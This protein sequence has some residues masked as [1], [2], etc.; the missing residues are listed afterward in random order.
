VLPLFSAILA[1]AAAAS[2]TPVSLSADFD[3]DGRVETA[4]ARPIGK[5]IRVE[6]ADARGK[7][8]AWADAAAPAGALD[9]AS[10]TLTG[11]PLG[12]P[13]VLLAVSSAAAGEQCHSVFR[14]KDRALTRVPLQQGG[15]QL[16]DCA[17][18]EGWTLQWERPAQDS[19]SVVV[20]Q[21]TRETPQG[22]HEERQV[23]AFTGFALELDLARSSARVGRVVIQTWTP[24]ILYTRD[25]LEIL[26]SRFDFTRFRAAP[27]LMIE[28][29][30][31]KGV[32][33]FHFKDK[34]G[35]LVAPVTEA[36]RGAEKNEL[37]LSI[38][39]GDKTTGVRV[40]VR[41]RIVTEVA[42]SGLD[43]RWDALYAPANRLTGAAVET[44]T[45]AEDEVASDMLPGLWTSEKGEQLAVNLVPGVLGVVEMRKAQLEVLLDPVPRGAD[46][47]LLP[48]DGSTPAWALVL[49]GGNGIARLPVRCARDGNAWN[50][51]PDGPAELFHRVGGRMNVR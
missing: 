19:P 30:P 27:R 44:F 42:V 32:F 3:G 9:P 15:R 37:Q 33:A 5:T 11:G 43:R 28:T 2:A 18:A 35:E 51:D 49:R 34:A 12:S 16:P 23:Y 14:F 26:K 36:G 10:L 1:L 25:A 7:R 46:V 20:R 4:T 41:D 24:A 40:T 6:I 38:R 29:D 13:G 8:L 39:V 47:L 31:D 22:P 21:R 17:P 45:R 50:C 48:R